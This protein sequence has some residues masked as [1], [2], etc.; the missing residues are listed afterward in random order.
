MRRLRR[1]DASPQE[2]YSQASRAVQVKTAL[3]RNVDPNTVDVETAAAAFQLD[4]HSRE[5]LRRL[6]ERSDE[7]RYSGAGNGVATVSPEHR[8]EVFDLIEHL[9]T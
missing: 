5:Q 9:Q 6:F 8:R 1:E 2:Y 7:V 3:A 4:D